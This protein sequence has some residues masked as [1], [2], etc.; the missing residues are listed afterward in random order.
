MEYGKPAFEHSV[1]DPYVIF[2]FYLSISISGFFMYISGF[3]WKSS[4]TEEVTARLVNGFIIQALNQFCDMLSHT[5][6]IA[7]S[8]QSRKTQIHSFTFSTSQNTTCRML[9]HLFRSADIVRCFKF[10]L[11]LCPEPTPG[12][13]NLFFFPFFCYFDLT[14][15]YQPMLIRLFIVHIQIVRAR[16]TSICFMPMKKLSILTMNRFRYVIL[17]VYLFLSFFKGDY[18]NTSLASD[19]VGSDTVPVTPCNSPVDLTRESS[20]E[21]PHGRKPKTRKRSRETSGSAFIRR[22]YRL[23]R[24]KFC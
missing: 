4:S 23:K 9:V 22:S 3:Y 15:F 18:R 13:L 8:F 2:F 21:S 5:S 1:F 11:D 20:D 17:I 10:E 16:H 12:M 7:P 19:Y 24:R 14:C 6:F